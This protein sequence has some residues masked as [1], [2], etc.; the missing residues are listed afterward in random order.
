MSQNAV[1]VAIEL[2]TVAVAFLALVILWPRI[3]AS[4]VLRW[5]RDEQA[6]ANRRRRAIEDAKWRELESCADWHAERHRDST[7]AA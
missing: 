2:L 3:S 1:I 4:K 5:E 7:E 6:R